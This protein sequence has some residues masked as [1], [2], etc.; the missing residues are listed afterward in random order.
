MRET[1]RK[2]TERLNGGPP[3]YAIAPHQ[4]L[5]LADQAVEHLDH[6]LLTGRPGPMELALEHPGNVIA[7]VLLRDHLMDAASQNDGAVAEVAHLL[8]RR[9]GAVA[10]HDG[11]K[12]DL[13][14]R[15]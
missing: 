1:R 13:Q 9:H 14:D 5:K 15:I 4:L 3:G 12:L 6:E 10:R 8:L 7:L 2:Y 11:V